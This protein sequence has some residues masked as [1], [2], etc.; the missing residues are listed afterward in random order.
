M[1][2]C[3][4]KFMRSFSGFALLIVALFGLSACGGGGGG[5]S[6]SSS[7][8]SSGTNSYALPSSVSTT[9]Q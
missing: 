5:G 7:G 3:K 2:V 4:L 9:G 6:G 1:L 8:A